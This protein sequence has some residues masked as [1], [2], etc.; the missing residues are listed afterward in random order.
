MEKLKLKKEFWKALLI[1]AGS[2]ILFF[3]SLLSL[4]PENK[5]STF[6]KSGGW[7]AGISFCIGVASFLI[8]AG[9]FVKMVHNIKILRI[10]TFLIWIGSILFFF[11]LVSGDYATGSFI[12]SAI[13]PTI[14][15]GVVSFVLL[16][17]SF[18]SDVSKNEDSKYSGAN[19]TSYVKTTLTSKIIDDLDDII[20]VPKNKKNNAM[21]P[22]IVFVLVSLVILYLVLSNMGSTNINSNIEN[23]S[24]QVDNQNLMSSL[25][26]TDTK[27]INNNS[28]RFKGTVRNS[29]GKLATNVILRVDFSKDK[30]MKQSFDTRYFTIDYVA[31]K[32]A[33]SFELPFELNFSGQYWWNAKVETAKFQ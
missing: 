15:L 9:S 25:T 33:Y 2:V 30:E 19:K 1:W 21:G 17:I 29:S 31:A 18:S 22:A 12:S 27:I 20:F 5:I 4:S 23:S 32:G 14:I 26:I 13:V 16:L 6:G 3:W 11:Y 8:A 7:I 10:T 28:Q 24:L